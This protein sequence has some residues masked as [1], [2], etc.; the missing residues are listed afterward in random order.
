MKKNYILIAV[1]CL[2]LAAC[3]SGKKRLEQ[4]DYDTAVYKAVKRL[5]QKPQHA[6]AE[7]VLRAAYTRAVNERMEVIAYQD[8]TDNI[9]KYDHMLK[10][11]QQIHYLNTA[12]RRY[13]LYTG[14]LTLTDVKAELAMMHREAALVHKSEG[15]RLLK[16]ADKQRARDAYHH[17]ER[18]NRLVPGIVSTQLIDRA[19]EAGTMNVALSFSNRSP[20]PSYNTDRVWSEVMSSFKN[21]RY[22]FLRVIDTDELVSTPDEIVQIAMEDAYIGGVDLS[23]SRVALS[24][25]DVYI[26]EAETDSGEVVKVYGTVTADYIEFCKTI[27][28]RASLQIQRV[29]GQTSAVKHRQLFPSSFNWTEKW[30]T[31]RGD[32]RALSAEQ[33]DFACLSE[34]NTPSPEWMLAQ[35]SQ[36]LVGRSI[37]FLRDQYGY[38]R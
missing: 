24:K 9:Y 16:I 31:Y 36:P 7:K 35:A 19:Q 13:P 32:K 20:Y 2:L 6:K 17:F 15:L 26:G 22:R 5:Q 23:K 14:L 3:S 21:T 4:G 37:S 25:E 27:N 10:Q 30:A 34:P 38:L 11:Y 18:A 8:Q 1:S 12:I 28:S 29:D 33:L